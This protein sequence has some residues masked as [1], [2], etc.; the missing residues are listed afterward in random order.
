MPFFSAFR[1]DPKIFGY[2]VG[3]MSIQHPINGEL[4]EFPDVK[5][6]KLKHLKQGLSFLWN[7]VKKC[8]P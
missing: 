6:S 1:I 8:I 3:K 5:P 7:A 4:N 2:H